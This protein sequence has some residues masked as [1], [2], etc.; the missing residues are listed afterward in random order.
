MSIQIERTSIEFPSADG[1]STIHGIVWQPSG[2]RPGGA[3]QLIHGMAEHIE[4]YDAFARFL[5]SH[6]YLVCG[7]D[8]IGHGHSVSDRKLLGHMPL[9]GGADILV[10]DV[11][12]LRCAIAQAFPEVPYFIFGHSMGSFVLRVY[13]TRHG[14]GLAGAILCGT[15]Q[16]PALLSA[17]GNVLTKVLAAFKGETAKSELVHSL[18]DGAFSRAME[19]PRTPFDWIS[20]NEDN[21]D[22]YAADDLN[23]FAFTLGGYASLTQLTALAASEELAQ[24]IPHELPLLFIAGAEDPVGANGAGVR[25]AAAL[26]ERAGVRDVTVILYDGMRHEILNE[27]EADRVFEDVLRWLSLRDATSP[28]LPSTYR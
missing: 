19:D 28:E 26:M 24:R 25:A 17:A 18:V 22:A 16:Q 6:G 3:V 2:R 15:G 11:D 9:H 12:T 20:A 13:L 14:Q 1:Q 23:G 8:H 7:H 4:R 10:E 21:V 5:A 27:R